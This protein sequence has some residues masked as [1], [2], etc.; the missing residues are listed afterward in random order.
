MRAGC[1]LD[2]RL[3]GYTSDESRSL[4]SSARFC[5]K[6][7]L[8]SFIRT[9]SLTYL[10]GIGCSSASMPTLLL[11]WNWRSGT[12]VK[13]GATLKASS[14]FS[15][16]MFSCPYTFTDACQRLCLPGGFQVTLCFMQMIGPNVVHQPTNE[17]RGATLPYG[18]I[19]GCEAL[20][21]SRLRIVGARR[22]RTMQAKSRGDGGCGARP[23]PID[24][25]SSEFK[26]R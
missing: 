4:G 11:P 8:A 3:V 19:E 5:A 10:G 13:A 9:R 7:I 21:A 22:I 2:A 26:K 23:A 6:L 17:A 1:D 14:V 16:Q 18:T 12:H 15:C 25:A 20:R 24:R